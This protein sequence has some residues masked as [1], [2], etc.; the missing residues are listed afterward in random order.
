V[1]S[2]GCGY[3]SREQ[4]AEPGRCPKCPFRLWSKAI[5]RHVR[6]HDLRHT[7]AT[8]LLKAGVPLQFVQRILRHLDPKLTAMTYGHLDVEDQRRAMA[9]FPVTLPP[10]PPDERPLPAEPSVSRERAAAVAGRPRGA[11]VGAEMDAEKEEGRWSVGRSQ[12]IQRPYKVGETGFEPA[13]PWSRTKCSTRLSHSPMLRFPPDFH[14]GSGGHGP[15]KVAYLLCTAR[16]VKDEGW[17]GIGRRSI[18]HEPVAKPLVDGLA[19]WLVDGLTTSG[20]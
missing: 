12:A 17:G 14:R 15:R 6:L 7:A 4:H 19:P 13:T 8:L 3:S 10:L 9:Q 5:P 16:G 2:Q 20:S 1:S 11:P 18:V